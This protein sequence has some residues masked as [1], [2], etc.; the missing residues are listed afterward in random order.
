MIAIIDYGM[1]NVGSIRNMLRRLGAPAVITR[2]AA[3]IRSAEKIILPG[4]GAFDRGMSNIREMGLLPILEEAAFDRHVPVLGICLGMQLL[5][6]KSEEGCLPGLGWIPGQVVRFRSTG[7]DLKVPHMGWNSVS[8]QSVGSLFD[9]L[10]DVARFYFVHSYHVECVDEFV[11]AETR[12][13]YDFVSSVGKG[14]ILGTQFHPEKSHRY[15]LQLL[16]NFVAMS[17]VH[18]IREAA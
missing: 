15:G 13:G 7:A 2:S 3:E 6:E 5:F 18:T 9:G 14:N 16:K 4:V 8:V 1:G 11:L 12:H 10:E 17:S